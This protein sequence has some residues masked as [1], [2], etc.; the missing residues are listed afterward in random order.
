MPRARNIKPKFFTNSKLGRLSPFHRLLF[1][2]LWTL[3][4][5]KGRLKDDPDEIKIQT[6]PYDDL[7][8]DQLLT[9]LAEHQECFISRYTVNGVAIIQVNNFEKHQNPHKSEREKGSE[10]PEKPEKIGTSTVQERNLHPTNP[11][12]SLNLIP[13]S[14]IPDSAPGG[15]KLNS[16]FQPDLKIKNT[17]TQTEKPEAEWLRIQILG[18]LQKQRQRINTLCDTLESFCYL[19]ESARKLAYS[20]LKYP[21]WERAAALAYAARQAHVTDELSY[22]LKALNGR[23]EEFEKLIPIAR[24]AIEAGDYLVEV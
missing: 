15:H 17:T 19:N 4:D 1:A 24:N 23:W 10:F 21:P 8:I 3:A 13:D 20:W 2:G 7:D 22:A 16:D 12:D 14:C 18:V 6:L 11:V 9:D 5:A